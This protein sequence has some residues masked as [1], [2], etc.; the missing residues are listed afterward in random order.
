MIEDEIY[1]SSTQFRIWSFTPD[2]LSSLRSDTNA[3][4]CER[5]RA[6]QQRAREV[7]RSDTPSTTGNLTPNP[8]DGEAKWEAALERDVDCV[9][10][11]EELTFVR[12]FCEQALELGDK[13]K[14]ALPTMVRATAIQFLRRFY[15]RN[16]I[17]TYHPKMMM[18]CALFLATK[19]DN[20]FISLRSF[21]KEVP[22][23]EKP[24]DVIA[25]EYTLTQG[26]RFTFDV[27][28]PFRGLEGGIMELQAIALGDG[29]PAPH[30]IGQTPESMK[31]ALHSLP[32]SEK[33]STSTRIA[34]AHG[35]AREILKTAAQMTDVYFLYTPSQIWLAALMIADKPLAQFYIDTKLGPQVEASDPLA[36]I[37]AKLQNTLSNCSKMLESYVPSA[38]SADMMKRLKAIAKK[39]YQCEQI[40]KLDPAAPGSGQKRSSGTVPGAEGTSESDMERVAKKRRLE[41]E[42]QERE[43]K[44]IFGG[45]LVTQRNKTTQEGS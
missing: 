13:Y 43:G 38:S 28:H 21:V 35:K 4:A 36:S 9:T 39:V 15:L 29:Q 12:Y 33:I 3:V 31:Q 34:N 17:M 11:E 23:L 6:A 30:G 26:L 37:R 1:R 42:K 20:Y 27:R 19:T 40:E 8:S 32:S 22:G 18:P 10:P 45:E 16:S 2:G 5:L 41:R 14:P 44:D 7:P 25:P 24:E